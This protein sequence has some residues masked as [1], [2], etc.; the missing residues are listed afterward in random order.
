MFN[1]AGDF[2]GYLPRRR[3]RYVRRVSRILLLS[4]STEVCAESEASLPILHVSMVC[5]ELEGLAVT[6]GEQPATN[7][8]LVNKIF[9]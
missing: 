3:C 6:V 9:I 5:Q 1:D 2:G 8:M 7:L 4:L